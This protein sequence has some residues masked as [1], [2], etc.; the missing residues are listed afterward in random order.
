MKLVLISRVMAT[1]NQVRPAYGPAPKGT[2]DIKN[3][4]QTQGVY[5]EDPYAKGTVPEP[6]DLPE[7]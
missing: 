3:M 6:R 7:L 4:G 2:A 5:G 1:Q